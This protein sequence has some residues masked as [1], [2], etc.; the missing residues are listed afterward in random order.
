MAKTLN[1]TRGV[2]RFAFKDPIKELEKSK[3]KESLIF[4]HFSYSGNRFKYTTSYKSCFGD[5]D[6]KKQRIK[7]GK[8]GLLDADKINEHLSNLE[9]DLKK[10]YSR[11]L[12]EELP[13]TKKVLKQYLDEKTGK[14]VVQEIEKISFYQS[15]EKFEKIRS[16]KASKNTAKQHKQTINIIKQYDKK[17]R[18]TFD[19][20][21]QEFYSQ[22]VTYLEDEAYALNTIGKHIKNLKAFLRFG[23]E[24]EH[25][26]NIKF[27][28]YLVPKEESISIYLD[29]NEI[30][31]LHQTDLSYNK[32]FEITRDVFL[33]GCYTGQRIS[34]YNGLTLNDIS[35]I[36]GKEY[37]QIFQQ[38]TANEVSVPI[39][40]EIREIMR[41]YENQ[42][43][44]K[45]Y[46]QDL[47]DDIKKICRKIGLKNRVKIIKT[48]GGKKTSE[49][50][51][52]Y[53]LVSSHTA[54]R[55]FCT[56]LYKEG[57]STIDIRYF[58]GHKSE[59]EFFNYIKIKDQERASH[60][61]ET[62]KYFNI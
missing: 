33:I 35:I 23:L 4:L 14:V 52:K 40:T 54:R 29:K 41:R 51:E 42:P 59:K 30:E 5:W 31:N 17:R 56:N 48:K 49:S 28:K 47:N 8:A 27:T 37:F 7:E 39:T 22:F 15:L 1:R 45:I 2:V 58:S 21:D 43:P 38:K 53:K 9:N 12:A 32:R 16:A 55:S 50:I 57:M 62:G 3:K 11:L 18:L 19:S 25:H 10:E 24:E 36:N 6:F 61:V 34:D 20:F 44:P 60:I 46:E 26:V 13:I